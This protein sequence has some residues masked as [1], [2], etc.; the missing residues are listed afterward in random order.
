LRFTDFNFVA[1]LLEGIEAS[2][3]ETATPVQEQVIP[4]ILSGKDVIASAQ[5]GTGKTAAFLLPV[6]NQLLLHPV[7]DSVGTLILVPTRELAI[8]ISQHVEGLSYFTNLSSIAIYG[9]SDAQNFVA[10]KKALQLGADIVVCTP[11]RLIA[12]LNMGYVN[13]KQLKFLVLDEADRML[14]M[15]FQDDINKILAHLPANRQSLLFSATMPEKI[16]ALARKILK[17]PTEI[18]IAISKPPEKIIQKAYVVHEPQKMPLISYLLKQTPYKNAVVFCSRKQTVKELTRNLKRSGFTVEEIHSDLEQTVR[19]NTL[20]AFASGR[21]PLL[22]ATDIISRGI[23]IDTIDLVVNWD[24]PDDG[25][26]YVHRIGRTARAEA[27]G[28]AYTLVSEV[29]QRKF[30]DIERLLEKEVE[31]AQV[32]AELG[33]TPAYEPNKRQVGGGRP[34]RGGPSRGGRPHGGHGYRGTSNRR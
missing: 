16:R 33:P 30:G 31:K 20:S 29:D 27:D 22:V 9:G 15:G 23:D 13:F 5:T 14:D 25:E 21:V 7:S 26:D 1:A 17:D 11:G 18:N 28:T 32:P 34:K 3:Y 8:Q 10:E 2:N 19:E 24:V 4:P 12:H 6:M